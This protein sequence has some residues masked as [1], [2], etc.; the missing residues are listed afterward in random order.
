MF[1][2]AGTRFN[3]RGIDSSGHVANYVETEMVTRIGE[4]YTSF[5]QTRGSI[6]LFWSQ[7]PNIKYKPKVVINGTADHFLACKTHLMMENRLHGRNVCINLI[8]D[9]GHEGQVCKQFS[10]LMQTLVNNELRYVYFNFHKECAKLRFDRLS[11]LMEKLATDL[12]GPFVYCATNE[13]AVACSSCLQP[14]V[15]RC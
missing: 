1:N 10:G 6:P 5:T 3:R 15:L 2:R 14:V 12:A 7:T 8:N 9:T 11:I 4:R 13:R